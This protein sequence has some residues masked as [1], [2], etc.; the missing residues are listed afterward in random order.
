MKKFYFLFLL[1]AGFSTGAF[2]QFSTDENN[3]NS[4]FNARAPKCW[5]CSKRH[6]SNCT[7][8]PPTNQNVPIDGGLGILLAA[9]ALYGAKRIRNN[10]AGTA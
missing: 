2:S 3:S 6:Y 8:P 4:G 10:K 1:I 9:G 5:K 7:P